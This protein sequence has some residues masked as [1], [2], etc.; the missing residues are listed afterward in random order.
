MLVLLLSHFPPR[1][2]T[3]IEDNNADEGTAEA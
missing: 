3:L 1:D 2:S